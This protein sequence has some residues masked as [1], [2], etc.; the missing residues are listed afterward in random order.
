M[1]G[2]AVGAG[3]SATSANAAAGA[4]SRWA[5]A[6]AFGVIALSLWF[7]SPMLHLLPQPGVLAVAVIA[8]LWHALSIGPLIALWR[9]KRDRVQ[10]VAAVSAVLVFGVLHG[11]LVAIALSILSAVRR[12]SQPV[13]HEL[14]ELG[15]SRNFV[16]LHERR[17]GAVVE[18]LLVLRP[19]EPPFFASTEKAMNEILHRVR[20]RGRVM[21]VVL[22]LEESSDLDSTAVECLLEMDHRLRTS[23]QS[24]S[25]ARV[26]DAVREL[27][28]RWD[29]KWPGK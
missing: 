6:I 15:S 11:M 28:M 9:M 29:P 21:A 13:V 22:S 16:A 23:G 7:A 5:G 19:E 27:L 2:M 25:L 14:V 4:V 1:Q 26:N 10:I 3:F 8:A 24:L 17:S 18:G 12:F 20:D